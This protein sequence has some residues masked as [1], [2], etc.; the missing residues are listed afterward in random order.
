MRVHLGH[1]LVS[2]T[3]LATPSLIYGGSAVQKP[4]DER[5]VVVGTRS[6][7]T[8]SESPVPVRL[9]TREELQRTGAETVADGLQRLPGVQISRDQHGTHISLQGL[10][11]RHVLVLVNGRRVQGR[12]AGS[13][14]LSRLPIAQI[15]RIEVLKGS[16]SVLYGS[17]AIGGVINIVLREPRQG[18]QAEWQARADSLAARQ[19]HLGMTY[20]RQKLQSSLQL[21]AR[22]NEGYDLTPTTVDTTAP[23]KR[24]LTA[25]WQLASQLTPEL[26][27]AAD[28]LVE[29][30]QTHGVAELGSG[31]ILDRRTTTRSEQFSL[32]PSWQPDATTQL[33]A[34]LEA[35]RF[36]DEFAEDQRRATQLDR[37]ETTHHEQ[38]AAGLHYA[39]WWSDN[40]HSQLGLEVEGQQLSSARITQDERQRRRHSAYW[41]HEWHIPSTLDLRLLPGIRIDQDSQFGQ[42][43][44]KKAAVRLEPW[45]QT[46]L[47]LSYGEGYRAPD[48]KELW[49]QFANPGVG[50]RVQG[51]PDLNPE[52]S[53]SVQAN[54][55]WSPSTQASW[56]VGLFHNRISDLIT[57]EAVEEEADGTLVYSYVNRLKAITRGVETSVRWRPGER[58]GL[59]VSYTYLEARDQNQGRRLA[60]RAPHQGSLELSYREVTQGWQLTG[61]LHVV[62]RRP[63][64]LAEDTGD[65][66]IWAPAYGDLNLTA[67]YA[68][69][70][71]WRIFGGVRNATADYSLTTHPVAPRAWFLGVRSTI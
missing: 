5:I 62:G 52:R 11:D 22:Q 64:Y 14:D 49:L 25:N 71:G 53:R 15:D 20:G 38:R 61:M 2:L 41:Q 32:E 42:A 28:L 6:A 8:L 30:W 18:W 48:F 24:N 39:G 46:L 59:A 56:S 51:N 23:A 33:R 35:G 3:L 47:R 55:E 66:T 63:I 57:T 1:I 26:R 67:S 27:L 36:E 34:R 44:T 12:L 31:A 4:S 21:T 70:D 69:A 54:L 9:L 29:H 19:G 17:D 16:S 37:T 10:A 7:R 58:W 40:H 43:V 45:A 65:V 13:P 68:L 60:G 50:Y